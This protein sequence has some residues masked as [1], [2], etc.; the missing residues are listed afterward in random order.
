M[1]L[2]IAYDVIMC[3]AAAAT[4]GVKQYLLNSCGSLIMMSRQA[5]C[6]NGLTMRLMHSWSKW[7]VRTLYIHLF[8]YIN[9]ATG[10]K[11]SRI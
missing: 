3:A 2:Y 10:S 4:R 7:S 8:L 5:A 6:F 11:A 9:F 1:I